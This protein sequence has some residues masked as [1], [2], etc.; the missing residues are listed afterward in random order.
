MIDKK[1][2]SYIKN[3]QGYVLGV[4]IKDENLVD[5]IDK[6]DK[7]LACD[8]I[9]SADSSDEN[10][11]CIPKTI[12]VKKIKRYYHYNQVQYVIL[13]YDELPYKRHFLNGS[14]YVCEKQIIIYSEDLEK[15]EKY[16]LKYKRY[17]ASVSK[18]KAKDGFIYLINMDNKKKLRFKQY[19]YNI[20][21]ILGMISDFISDLLIN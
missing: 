12:N 14:A 15:L 7:I 20:S 2:R 16:A 6:N 9:L 11:S 3:M 4:G 17:N 19:L 5:L 21:D 13:N 1:L 8:L 10:G 18:V